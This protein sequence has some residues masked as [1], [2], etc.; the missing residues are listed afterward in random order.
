MRA[1]A[2]SRCLFSRISFFVLWS[3]VLGFLAPPV[4]AQNAQN[5]QN[6]L[7]PGANNPPPAGAI[8]DLS[9]TPVPGGG[10]QTY[11]QYSVSFVATL[12][13]TTI[14]F[15]FR[16]DPA[17]LFFS[18]P[19]VVDTADPE[20]NLLTNADF[21]GGTDTSNGNTSTPVGWNYANQYGA[22]AGG[23]LNPQC[24][25]IMND[26]AE[27]CW[28]DGAVQAYDALSQS[29]TT[30]V[31]HTY[32]ITFWL[33]DDSSCHCNFSD[34]STNGNTT[35]TGGNGIN[36]TVYAQGGLPSGSQVTQPFALDG[37]TTA[38][39]NSGEG[40]LVQQTIDTTHAGSLT[41]NGSEGTV[42]CTGI[43]L[44]STN[45][46]VSNGDPP[47]NPHFAS[48]V[49]G[50]PFSTG[51]CAAR[52]GD[53][54]SG[55]LCSLYVNACYGGN[56][57]IVL[58]NASD[59]YCPYVSNPNS[60]NNYF[61]LND[62]WDPAPGTPPSIMPGTTVSLLDFVPSIAGE[63]WSPSNAAPNPVCTQVAPTTSVPAQCEVSDSLVD[64]YGDQT[65]T[66]GTKPKKGWL[67]S[68]FNVPMLLSTVQVFP[69]PNTACPLKGANPIVLNDPPTNDGMP[70]A[71]IWSNGACML[72]FLV[73]PAQAPPAPN[74]N[75]VAAPP[76]SLFYG[77][78]MPA[79]EPG[80]IPNGDFGPLTNAN[81][82]CTG[83]GL[84]CAAQ[85]WETNGLQP[86]STVF[87]ATDG[88]F[89]LHWSTK[90]AAGITEK[91]IVLQSSGTCTT[92]G[93]GIFNAPCYT[94]N[95]FTTTVNLDSTPPTV[96][97]V[98]S[99]GGGTYAVNQAATGVFT[100]SDPLKNFVASGVATCQAVVDGGSPVN[101]PSAATLNTATAGAHTVTVTAVDNA[102][103]ATSQVFNYTVLADAV[104]AIFEQETS[105]DVKPGH[106]LTYVAWA[107]DLS[108]T[109]AAETTVTEQIQLTKGIVQFS[110]VTA[111]VALVSCSLFGCS[112][113]PPA[114]G[115]SCS[116]SGTSIT[117]TI[118]TLPS[119]YKLKGAVIKTVISVGAGSVVGSAFKITATVNSPNDLNPK[120]NATSDLITVTSK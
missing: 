71:T 53:G 108:K 8:L 84:A 72:G 4:F 109:D 34:I 68:V 38:T 78:G 66:R 3:A 79:V 46:T 31:G 18:S 62:T 15:A 14:T 51:L 83:I 85:S 107:L 12:T 54:G 97:L 47:N 110:N 39:F 88:S 114:G 113:M 57:G 22:L 90:D 19:S 7:D 48:F 13:S 30:I 95:Y 93:A 50:T 37:T 49:D 43:Q 98:F 65:T 17:F 120:N 82:V 58:A 23:V 102:G 10:N 70:G 59:Y 80:P 20:V 32:Q 117:C 35:G 16:E 28:V 101:Y 56:S 52:P 106:N 41:C 69:N 103:N 100:C 42:D 116:V 77:P 96:A 105:D 73:N 115:S 33:A 74:N 11:Q 92:G 75:F 94:T 5:I 25:I 26:V 36:E 91:S 27:N 1:L 29:I 61:T 6:K 24:G 87:G 55:N 81:A 86:L 44:S 112:S 45:M 21:S 67:I 9:G 99:P 64:M 119:L 104:V 40:N 111:N 60:G 2:H 63:T 76:A 118:G 89:I